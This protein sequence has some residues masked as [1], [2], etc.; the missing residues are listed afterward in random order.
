MFEVGELVEVTLTDVAHGGYMLGRVGDAVIFVRGAILGETVRAQI[1][2]CRT[3]FYRALAVEILEVSKFRVP[4]FWQAGSAGITGAADFGHIALSYQR[5][6]KTK[7]LENQ[8][9][10]IGGEEILAQFAEL[11]LRVRAV[12]LG[13]GVGTGTGAVADTS[14][15]VGVRDFSVRAGNGVK[16]AENATAWVGNTLAQSENFLVQDG[17]QY[18]SRVDLVKLEHG[19]G[20]HL[21]RSNKAIALQDMPL[22]VAGLAEL[23]LFGKRWDEAIA[24]GQRVRA[25]VP[26]GGVPVLVAGDSVFA[27]PN[28]LAPKR[29]LE[30][31]R[32]QGADYEYAVRAN[33]FWQVHRQAPSTLAQFVL[34]GLDVGRGARVLDLYAG[35]GLFSLPLAQAVGKQGS[36][37]SVEGSRGAVADGKQNLRQYAWARMQQ[38]RIDARNVGKLVGGAD[39]VV[40]DPPRSGLGNGVA[41]VL[42][43]SEAKTVA[44][45]SCDPAAMARDVAAMIRFGRRVTGFAAFDIFPNTHHV[46]C[47]VL[48]SKV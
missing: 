42:A 14:A 29:V 10:R 23:E 5:E 4:V 44:L 20:M 46:E 27:T 11:D 18:R 28:T 26:S 33:G 13:A 43:E 24:A 40:A 45:I 36:V 34:D 6:L 12:N 16:Q 48:M 9:R 8:L 47:V 7:V 19:F 3:K 30:R 17:W 15:C 22:A 39:F 41:R 38:L 1:T 37:L 32:V 21:E 31:M 2:E 25:V 35:A